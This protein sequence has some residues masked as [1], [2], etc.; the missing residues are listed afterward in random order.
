MAKD[1][2]EIVRQKIRA[3]LAQ[4]IH[5]ASSTLFDPEYDAQNAV[6]TFWPAANP[7]TGHRWF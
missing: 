2:Q 3:A 7:C 6:P 5:P 1:I 4:V